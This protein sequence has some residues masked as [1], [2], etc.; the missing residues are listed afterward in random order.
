M[1]GTTEERRLGLL[2]Y[3]SILHKWKKFI[4]INVLVILILSIVYSLLIPKTYRAT[5]T[6]MLPSNEGLGGLSS[7]LS[8]SG[9]ALSIGA[10]IFGIG[11]ST[12]ED[13]VLGI[14]YSR[15][16]LVETMNQFDLY[17]YYGRDTNEIDRTLKFFVG[18]VSFEPN[19]FGLIEVNVI[20]EDPAKS[21]EIANYLVTLADSIHK[22]L[23]I[24]QARNNRK[25]VEK[26]FMQNVAELKSAED[27]FT[28][29]QKK[30]G[31]F[32]VPEQVQIAAAAAGELEAELVEKQITLYTLKNQFGENSALVR[33]VQNQI[34][35]IKKKKGELNVESS[36]S[37]GTSLLIPF[38]DIP[39]LQIEY[40]RHLRNVEVQNK[41]MEFLY[42]IYEQSRLEEQKS[43]PTVLTVDIAQPPQIKHAPK[44]AFIVIT[45]TFFA[46][47]ISI[48]IVF[49]G[50]RFLRVKIDENLIEL[51][52]KQFFEK[53]L[54]F[55]RI[56]IH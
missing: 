40:L 47:F 19:E 56:R 25:F 15:T 34:N 36:D 54:S 16:V 46:L 13:L 27:L 53:L 2:D 49:I 14:L 55:Y 10:K 6:I 20:N 42:P 5:A 50:E 52:Y 18:D 33:S 41:I 22:E 23:K 17:E 12:S 8:N 51:K 37:E 11:S 3:L 38:D 7:L 21:A 44:R 32:A 26:R 4:V 35:A 29:F 43:I 39:E 48:I 1:E 9:G 30:Y 28:E 24:T 45:F 31:V